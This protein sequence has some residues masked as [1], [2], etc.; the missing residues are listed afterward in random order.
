[1][2]KPMGK[3]S[4]GQKQKIHLVRSLLNKPSLILWDEPFTNL[5]PVSQKEFQNYLSEYVSTGNA[6]AVIATHQLNQAEEFCTDFAFM[7]KGKIIYNRAAK[8][9]QEDLKKD[10]NLEISFTQMPE[11]DILDTVLGPFGFKLDVLNKNYDINSVKVIC[12]GTR[13]EEQIPDVIDVLVKSGL[14][15]TGVK[16]GKKSMFDFYCGLIRE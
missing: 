9:I 1:M 2:S 4:I 13:I 6:A 8:E 10:S 7:N 16:S 12:S 5:D 3:I 11:S 15:I 14:K